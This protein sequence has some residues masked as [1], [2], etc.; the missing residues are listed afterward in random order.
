MKNEELIKALRHCGKGGDITERCL[1]CDYY[2]REPWCESALV[3][4]AAD[5]LE[6]D[7]KRIADLE[8]ALAACRARNG[9][10]MPKKGEWIE[11]NT[12][13]RSAQFYCSVCHRTCYDIQPTRDKAW[14]KRCRY[15]YCPNC[16]ARMRSAE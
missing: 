5:T 9:E 2:D 6:A 12:R 7:E 16:G 11:S 10:L 13:P 1:L 8:T 14:T 4:D 15:H 3:N